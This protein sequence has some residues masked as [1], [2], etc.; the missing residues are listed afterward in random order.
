MPV[1][2]SSVIVDLECPVSFHPSRD[3]EHRN[4]NNGAHYRAA[5]CRQGWFGCHPS[6]SH[7][8]KESI[9]VEEMRDS[10]EHICCG[11]TP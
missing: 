6:G 3:L 1:T 9:R 7:A 2:T 10:R 8:K 4:T 5:N 11:R